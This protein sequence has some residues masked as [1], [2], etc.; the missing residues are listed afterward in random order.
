M[1]YPKTILYEYSK[2]KLSANSCIKNNIN[3]VFILEISKEDWKSCT[4][5]R[6]YKFALLKKEKQYVL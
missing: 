3:I 2:I 4:Y 6:S 5:G 1:P